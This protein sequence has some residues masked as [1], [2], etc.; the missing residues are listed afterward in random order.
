MTNNDPKEPKLPFH[1][2]LLGLLVESVLFVMIYYEITGQSYCA[3]LMELSVTWDDIMKAVHWGQHAL[4]WACA[5]FS[6][7]IQSVW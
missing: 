2:T 1:K 3:C 6:R 4:E 7:E 5:V